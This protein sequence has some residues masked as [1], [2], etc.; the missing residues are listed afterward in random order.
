MGDFSRMPE[1]ETKLPSIEDAFAQPVNQLEFAFLAQ[2][3]E[4]KPSRPIPACPRRA[5]RSRNPRR[6]FQASIQRPLEEIQ[7]EHAVSNYLPPGKVLGLSLTDNRYS[8]ITVKRSG[9]RYQV[10]IHR[11]FAGSEPRLVRALA[12]YIVHND[13]PASALLGDFIEK[14][15]HKITKQA[16]PSKSLELKTRGKVYDLGEIFRRLNGRYF[17]GQHPARITWGNTRG[18]ADR[19][20][21]KVG[22]YS[23][24]DRLIRVHPILDQEMVP[25]YFLDWIVFHEMLHGKHAVRRIGKRRCFHSPE[26]ALEERKFPEYCRARLWEK[27]NL[28]RLLEHRTV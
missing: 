2:A 25:G 18:V 5:I 16:K 12:R 10:R 3:G 6:N 17:D 1:Y 9:D 27:A 11:M 22:S 8:I 14:N 7:L 28:N 23:V 13:P 19:R 24:E 4:L 15:Q 26:F 20:S 21:V